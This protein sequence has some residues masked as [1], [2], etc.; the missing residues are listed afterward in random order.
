MADSTDGWEKL[1]SLLGTDEEY[2]T[3]FP[4]GSGLWAGTARKTAGKNA[5]ASTPFVT[6]FLRSKDPTQASRNEYLTDHLESFGSVYSPIHQDDNSLSRAI[7]ASD[8]FVVEMGKLSAADY[9]AMGRVLQSSQPILALS[10]ARNA[11]RS[12]SDNYMSHATFAKYSSKAEAKD[13][14]DD[15][16]DKL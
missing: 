14:I 10:N 5:S 1:I 16:F 6:Y 12:F 11:P 3:A 4:N 7:S 8:V 15:F 13:K 2:R 9:I